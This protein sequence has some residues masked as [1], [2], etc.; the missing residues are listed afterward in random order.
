ME[1]LVRKMRQEDIPYVYSLG[2]TC[3]DLRSSSYKLWTIDEI[4][5]HLPNSQDHCFVAVH[6]ENIVGFS[7]GSA[8]FGCDKDT[9]YI[10]WTAV[11]PQ[12]HSIG[13]GSRL[14]STNL[15]SLLSKQK[16]QVVTDIESTNI[17]AEKMVQRLGFAVESTLNFWIK[18]AHVD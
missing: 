8:E 11:H 16:K 4:A 14:F 12:Y 3:F 18:S 10:E 5:Q 17:G 15:A 9:G 7:L 6:A 13:L 1:I 2:C